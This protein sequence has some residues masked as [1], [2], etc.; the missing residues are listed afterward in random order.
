MKTRKIAFC[1]VIF[2]VVVGIQTT[3]YGKYII[4]NNIYRKEFGNKLEFEHSLDTV[5][6]CFEEDMRLNYYQ[7]YQILQTINPTLLLFSCIML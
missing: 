3:I 5:K 6:K 2:L 7:N 1:I 4:E